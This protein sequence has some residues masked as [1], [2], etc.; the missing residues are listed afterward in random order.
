MV[1]QG[2]RVFTIPPGCSFLPTLVDSLLNGRLVGDLSADPAALS[3]VTLYVPT[4]RAAR[5]LVALLAE[6][7]QGKAQLLPR[8]VPPGGAGQGEAPPADRPALPA[9]RGRVRVD[10]SRG[11]PVPGRG[12]PQTA[13]PAPGAAA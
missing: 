10:V 8:V 1:S 2:A 12:H 6:R 9:C 4:R 3:D 13:D 11:H 7:G 5:A